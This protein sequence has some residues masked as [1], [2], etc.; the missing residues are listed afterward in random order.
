MEST[1]LVDRG[2]ELDVKLG[3]NRESEVESRVQSLKG[4]CLISDIGYELGGEEKV[5]EEKEEREGSN[6]RKF[7]YLT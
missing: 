1:S 4:R 7:Q 2:G 3:E 5:G 6:D